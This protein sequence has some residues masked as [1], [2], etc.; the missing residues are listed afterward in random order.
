MED[1]ITVA[2]GT[3]RESARI[4]VAGEV[5]ASTSPKLAEAID[6]ALSGSARRLEINA[7]E[8]TFIDSAGLRVLV[9][10]QR[11]AEES[12]RRVVVTEPSESIRRLLDI[13]GLSAYLLA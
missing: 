10:A 11:T 5:D 1:V 2:V 3:D 8:V 9:A 6:I 13:T 4:D 12:G 7:A